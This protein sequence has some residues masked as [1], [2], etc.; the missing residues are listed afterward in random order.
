MSWSTFEAHQIL[1]QMKQLTVTLMLL[2]SACVVLAQNLEIQN[3]SSN[4]GFDYDEQTG[5]ISDL[6]FKPAEGDGTDIDDDFVISWG[7]QADPNDP[8]TYTEIDRQTVTQ[9]LPAFNAI[10]VDNWSDQNLNDFN[11]P[12][13][14]YLVVAKVDTDDDIAETDESDNALFLATS[15]QDAFNFTPSTATDV[16]SAE[17]ESTLQLFP[18]FASSQVTVKLDP[19]MNG[20]QWQVVS[21][22]GQILQ[23][24]QY[25]GNSTITL[26]VDDLAKGM[27]LFCV[28]H[29]QEVHSIS[30]MKM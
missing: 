22:C 10:T 14:S 12:A 3:L 23:K 13:G 29:K 19:A 24:G 27:Y 20:A 28:T 21:T 26:T 8:G 1:I 6:F 17:G 4:W 25:N 5:V 18:A 11:L 2:M 16:T 7:V 15:A 9:T 30:F